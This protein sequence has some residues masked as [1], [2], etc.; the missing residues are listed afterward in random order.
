M[1][2]SKTN[3]YEQKILNLLRG[4][5][6]SS[7][8]PYI[9]LFTTA[10]TE[11]SDGTELDLE[12]YVRQEV[13]FGAPTPSGDY[14]EISNTSPVAFPVLEGTGEVIVAVGY[15]DAESGG[16]LCYYDDAVSAITIDPNTIVEMNVGDLKIREN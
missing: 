15:F 10:P 3:F 14:H 8:T 13:V 1:A 4:D 2:G 11:S 9:A 12:N 16:N 7:W 5:T 6:V